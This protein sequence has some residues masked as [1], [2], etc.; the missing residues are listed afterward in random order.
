MKFQENS[1]ISIKELIR[2]LLG[3]ENLR[4]TP[5]DLVRTLKMQ[6]PGT[7]H[8]K[9]KVSIQ[10]LV[11]AGELTYS[12]H[13]SS[14]QLELSSNGRMKVSKRLIL[15]SNL[16]PCIQFP[17]CMEIKMQSGSAFG[18]GDHPTTLLA[19]KSIDQITADLN[20]HKKGQE[21]RC[22]DIGTGTGIL[23]IAATILGITKAIAIDID[24]LACYE[25]IKNVHINQ[26]NGKVD[27]VAG[28]LDA[29]KPARYDLITANLRPPT[30]VRLIPDI[31]L[32]TSDSGYWILSGFRPD[33]MEELQK[34]LPDG[35]KSIGQECNRNWAVFTVQR[36]Q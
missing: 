19:L 26:L 15:T 27:V 7:H 1:E 10:K 13:F 17:D 21:T 18:K 2:R 33:E 29:L 34:K 16:L 9:I 24:R 11:E 6:L 30:L 31:A 36:V 4:M 8:R 12:H 25:A 23:A 32:S 20:K 5:T 22:L 28:H 14:S 3:R 35:F